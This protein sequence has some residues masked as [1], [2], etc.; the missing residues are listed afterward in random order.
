MIAGN[1]TL[2]RR[3]S[4]ER[5]RQRP[6][7]RAEAETLACDLFLVLGSS[8]VVF[9]AASFPLIAKTNGASLAI[10]NRE[11]TEMDSAAD[12]VLRDEIGPALT[13]VT[14]AN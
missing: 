7:A 1:T 5:R 4:C 11:P 12:L 9:P 6:M 3:I 2:R 13:A 8:L 14:P 10:V